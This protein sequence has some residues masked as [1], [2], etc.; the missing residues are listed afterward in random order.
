MSNAYTNRVWKQ[1]ELKGGKLLVMLALAGHADD[2]G[3]CWPGMPLL[4]EKTRL[5]DRQLRRVLNELAAANL[6]SIEERA[7]G[8]GKRPHYRLFPAEKAD[9]LTEEKR[10]LL[11]PLEIKADISDNKSGHFVHGKADISDTDYSHARSESPIESPI[12][13]DDEDNARKAHGSVFKAWSEN[14]PGTM[15]PILGDK[16]HELIDECGPP[17]VIYGIVASVESGARNFKYIAA[18]AR[19]HAAGKEPPVKP[20]PRS[21]T[22]GYHANGTSKIARSLS[23]LDEYEAIKLSHG[24]TT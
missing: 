11:P 13:N 9:I 5:T 24:V 18:C 23:A 21:P 6:I 16:L 2:A 3:E 14:I 19:N 15:T 8:R 10:T 20:P 7:I 17:A 1:K 12:R 4:I 22:N